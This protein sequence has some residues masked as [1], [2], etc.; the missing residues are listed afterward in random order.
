M[1]NNK[2][3]TFNQLQ[4]ALSRVKT[5]L[6]GK[7]NTSHG[8]HVPKT[9]TA[10]NARFLRNDNTWQTITPVNIG[11]ADRSHTHGEYINQN[12]FTNV[13][14]GDTTIEADSPTDT[15]TLNAGAN[16]TI[17]PDAINDTVTIEAKD[18]IYTHPTNPGNRHIPSGG[19]SGQILRW[20]E[21]GTAAWGSENNTFTNGSVG[22]FTVTPENLVG[23][24][25]GMTSFSGHGYAF[26]AGVNGVENSGSAPFRVGHDGRLYAYEAVLAGTLDGNATTATRLQAAHKFTIGNTERYFNGTADITWTLSDIGAAASGHT[27]SYIPLS[28]SSSITGNLEFS[29]SG[30]TTRGIIGAVGDN[31]FWRIVGGATASNAGYLEIATA[32]DANEPIYVR[33]YGSGKFGTLTRTATLL[34]G[35]GNTFFPGTVTAPTFSGTLNGKASKA[36]RL[37]TA[38]TINGT[39]FNGSANI[40]T[41]NW[42]TA[43]TLT[44]GNS[45]KSV[46]G[47]G[48]VSWTLDEIGAASIGHGHSQIYSVGVRA[49]QATGERAPYVGISMQ[50]S[51]NNGYPYPYGNIINLSGGG[52]GQLYIGWSG[53][54]GAHAPVYVRSKRDSGD[55]WS[56]WAQFYTT[57]NP[58]TD[59]TGNAGTATKL[60]T[61]KTITIGNTGKNFDGSGNVS[62]S[63]AEIGAAASGHTHDSI[64][65]GNTYITTVGNDTYSLDMPNNI[66]I[67]S[68]FGVS[69][70]N[71]CANT[72]NY[73]QTTVAINARTGEASFRGRITAHGAYMT[74]NIEFSEAGTSNSSAPGLVWNG[75]TDGADLYYRTL[76]ADQGQLLINLRDDSNATLAIAWNGEVKATFDANG[77]YSGNAG[78][79][80]RLQNARTFTVGNTG[81]NFD[82][83]GNISWSIDEIGAAPSSHGHNFMYVKGTNTIGSVND[84]TTANWGAQQNSVHWYG[85]VEGCLHDQPSPWGY[86]LNIGQSSEVH[87]IWM[88]QAS[89]NLS[90]RGGNSSGWSGTWKTILD[91]DNYS[92]YAAAKSHTHNYAASNHNHD[93]AY[94]K[95]SGGTLSGQLTVNNNVQSQGFCVS[96]NSK[97][98]WL[99]IGDNDTYIWA[100]GANKSLQITHGGDLNFDGKPVLYGGRGNN[101]D[102]ATGTIYFNNAGTS[103]KG[104]VSCYNNSNGDYVQLALRNAS[105]G[106]NYLNIYDSSIRIGCDNIYF[107]GKKF[108]I[109]ASAPSN[110]SNGD[111]WINIG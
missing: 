24:N 109:A 108:T 33:Q 25:V 107:S 101:Y 68:W 38:R 100:S 95:L 93:S 70:T 84:D 111:V 7:A 88:E 50:E 19:S 34:D 79:A 106:V 12:T 37:T 86:L 63:L 30:T 54:T 18:T 71:N 48:N 15:L 47:S 44:I 77:Y 55:A 35:S 52:E 76:E 69:I 14:I 51:Y 97:E 75:S 85:G 83:T 110:P 26:W 39:S 41:A 28:G 98:A 57:A 94:L 60:A 21:D 67:S 8:N 29:N 4:N 82:G 20:S 62:W 53:T 27:H 78:S 72:E 17:T 3:I 43:R 90:H 49:P 87:Q 89:G 96:K 31:D 6:D 102:T 11:A 105:D 56:D 13:K 92:T 45:G 104:R 65:G 91:S 66:D 1:A 81:K 5:A 2:N 42:G 16:V 9:E 10:N 64:T 103:H 59:I 61:A 36:D 74:N 40:T 46:N 22:G 80:S 58:Q 99:D 32:D 73:R 23:N